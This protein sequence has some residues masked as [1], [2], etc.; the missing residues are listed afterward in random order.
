MTRSF[1]DAA[2]TETGISDH[3]KLITSFFRLHFERIPPQK[4]EYRN[5]KKFDVT[6]FLRDLDQE[7]IQGEMYKYNNDMYSTFS[8]VFISVLDRH[9]TLKRKIIRGNQ[10]PF[11]T[12]QL[13]KAIMNRSKQRNR[14]IKWP[15]RENF[16]GYKKAK[17]KCN[18]LNKFA[19]KSY[20]DKVTSK[21]FVC[22]KAFWNTVKPFLTNRGFLTNENM[23]IKH[24][25]KIVTDNSKLAHLFNN[26]YINS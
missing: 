12:K 6:N 13:S 20:F 4:V 21:G 8:D 1:H 2:V 3:N 10:E 19:K 15:S 14:Y 9:A 26:R 5:Y 7:M 24:K 11:I 25:D 17:N 16:L 18:N 23:T 22:N